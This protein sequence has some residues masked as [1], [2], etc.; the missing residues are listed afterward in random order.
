PQGLQG[1]EALSARHATALTL[2]C[3]VLKEKAAPRPAPPSLLAPGAPGAHTAQI[4]SLRS[5]AARNATFLLALILIGS[6]VAGLGPMRAARW[7]TARMP[8]PPM[9]MREPFL[10]C[11]TPCPTKSLSIVSACFF[12]ISCSSASEAARCLR[13]TVAWVPAFCVAIPVSLWLERRLI[14]SRLQSR[15]SQPP[16]QRK[17]SPYY[18]R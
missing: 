17:K 16:A 7:R 11:F 13:V 12:A 1:A 10:R 15:E 14:S 5:F 8:S 18:P 6:P 4:A 9:R 2:R 3:T